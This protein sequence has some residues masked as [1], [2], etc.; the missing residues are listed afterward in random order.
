MLNILGFRKHGKT[1]GMG[2]QI[3]D[4]VDDTQIGESVKP[5]IEIIQYGR[6]A[7]RFPKG[8]QVVVMGNEIQNRSAFGQKQGY[9]SP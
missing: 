2:Y 6:K 8:F 3:S 7:R 5:L 9:G 1:S 4:A